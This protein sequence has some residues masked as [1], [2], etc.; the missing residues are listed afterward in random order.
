MRAK[1]EGQTS[2]DFL[3]T[4]GWALLLIVIVI[5]ALFAL[6]VFNVGSF[7]GPTATGFAQIGMID[8]NV[9][10]SGSLSL[11]LQNLA[12]MDIRV[13]G[14]SGLYGNSNFSY[15][16]SNVSIPNGEASDVFNVGTIGSVSPGLYYTLPLRITYTDFSGFNYTETGTISGTVGGGAVSPSGPV[17]L[18]CGSN[19]TSDTTLTADMNCADT[20][21]FISA[22]HVTL[23]CNG[24]TIT[25]A[26]LGN[27]IDNSGGYDYTTV[28][29][30]NITGFGSGIDF[31]NG[32]SYGTIINNTASSNGYAGIY[33]DYCS[34]S[35]VSSNNVSSN[36]DSGIYIA[37]GS[38]HNTVANNAADS[39]SNNGIWIDSSPSN[40]VAD[41][42]LSSNVGDGI[43]LSSS[44][45]N[46]ITGNTLVNNDA[47]KK[48]GNLQPA[49]IELTSSSNN[50]L[51]GNTVNYSNNNG[52]SL[53]T[54]KGGGN[55][56]NNTIADNTLSS[57]VAEGIYLGYGF[58]NTIA[59]N[60]LSSNGDSG[61]YLT[62]G[63]TYNTI[64]SNIISNNTSE[65]I[66]ID[67]SS[68]NPIYN[69]FLNNSVDVVVDDGSPN[70]WN[71]T[72]DCSVPGAN[73]I[74]GDC[75][76]G[77]F[78]AQPDG[79]G[80][81]ENSTECG[82]NESGI[83]TSNYTIDDNNI[84]YLPLTNLTPVVPPDDWPMFH[85]GLNRTGRTSSSGPLTNN[86]M[87]I[88]ETGGNMVGSPAVADGR[89]YFGVDTYSSNTGIVFALDA[90]TGSHI[91]NYTTGQYSDSP[92]AVD[93]G[94]VYVA[95]DNSLF[96]LNATDGS[97]I[98]NYTTEDFVDSGPAV[99]SGMVYFGSNDHYAYALNVT[100]GSLVWR[101]NL[102]S[103]TDSSPS[104]VDGIVYIGS[105]DHNI[106]AL[107]ATNGDM[108]W[109]Y[110]TGD[111]AGSA[112]PAVADGVLYISSSSSGNNIFALNATNG[113]LIWD[114]NIGQFAQASP[115]IA[116]GLVYV[117]SRYY[118]GYFY[119]LNITDGSQIWSYH[120]G[121]VWSS[122]AIAGGVVYF[123]SE[124]YNFHALNAT[125]GSS[126]WSYV[127]GGWLSAS[128]AV[129]NGVVYV[130]SGDGNVYA[131]WTA[132]PIELSACGTISAPG[133]YVLNGGSYL[134]AGG[135]CFDI[136]TGNAIFDCNGSTITGSSSG[137]GINNTG[138]DNVTVKNCNIT[139]FNDGIEFDGAGNGAIINNNVSVNG[140][141]G[142]VLVSLSTTN[143]IANNTVILNGQSGIWLDSSTNN[144]L[145]NNT[146]GA[147][148]GNG[149]YLSSSSNNTLSSN[150]PYGNGGSGISIDTGSNYNTISN[151]TI[152]SN[153]NNGIH[154]DSSSNNNLIGN[155]LN[156][157]P[158][159]NGIS[160]W[161]GSSNN[162]ITNNT[163]SSNAGSIALFS[164]SNNLFYNNIFNDSYLVYSNG[165]SSNYW[166]TTEQLGMN[167]IG[168]SGIGGNY[169]SGFSD[170]SSC[171]PSSPPHT[172]ICDSA[173]QIPN[174]EY[175]YLPLTNLSPHLVLPFIYSG[176]QKLDIAPTDKSEGMAWGCYEINTWARSYT[177]GSE[178]TAIARDCSGA[179][180][181][182]YD[183]L[184][185]GYD[186]WYLPAINQLDD[187]YNQW[188]MDN[189]TKEDYISGW[190]DFS[191]SDG[192]YLSS[193]ESSTYMSMYHVWAIRFD[194]GPVMDY[195]WK[196]DNRGHVR[197]V[198]D[199]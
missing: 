165:G 76:G 118:D 154:L 124:D 109:S 191:T 130:G 14:V 139:G 138:H 52:I 13:T 64:I 22:D 28:E 131:F 57:N 133:A 112:A 120:S 94:V 192:Y 11:K 147:S 144:T 8:W 83:C 183:S 160:F 134:S 77:N 60:T 156:H 150:N 157:N 93:N 187:M 25:G 69:N 20:A 15:I 10:N 151:N 116:D 106:Y 182:C 31:E 81:S 164:S 47:K 195:W 21:L 188:R 196:D 140:H 30:C 172:G 18:A 7:T 88:Y 98:W 19:I 97:H 99:S 58:N 56:G 117:A 6:G 135:D 24:S 115:A 46:N 169:W 107:N 121:N 148:G 9:N 86:T 82:A 110:D 72:L 126:I 184:F 71:T 199:G 163:F 50:I 27:G 141:D 59:D 33:M 108:I 29:N 189:I 1:K 125:D 37:D 92:P 68:D 38:T 103:W 185:D 102:G 75:I 129:V 174:G 155:N 89:V 45:G 48:T 66:W 54:T 40:I 181:L 180:N 51:T 53:D 100:D 122:S 159:N 95:G 4:Y 198:R 62:E 152:S 175:D 12:G 149:I 91:W 136:Q 5:G 17:G 167:I 35:T 127:T 32:A 170:T 39:N 2:F 87:W 177:N 43:D 26:G 145:T 176:G 168:Y 34:D 101:Y 197:C 90:A 194:D 73:I 3:M 96:A 178:N 114:Y 166:N 161:S 111:S 132:P 80:W 65:G 137:D 104:V 123:G 55:S 179:A 158:N 61:I 42:T 153:S 173:Y 143:T 142:I 128:P 162:T 44:D 70:L 41:N 105:N 84:D 146:V 193:T 119:A 67:S 16:I 78:Y 113:S 85:H 79:N 74:G 36:G 186:D 63:S 171:I 23:D 190:A 49:G